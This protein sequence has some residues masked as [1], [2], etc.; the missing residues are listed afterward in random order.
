MLRLT[1]ALMVRMGLALLV[2]AVLIRLVPMPTRADVVAD[3]FAIAVCLA[4][5]LGPAV[6]LRLTRDAAGSSQEPGE[7]YATTYSRARRQH[8][9]EIR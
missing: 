8:E 1:L 5:V 9:E 2:M 7:T 4:L 6:Y 3:D